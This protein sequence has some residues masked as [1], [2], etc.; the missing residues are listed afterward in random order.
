MAISTY[1]ELKTAVSSWT[2]RSDFTAANLSDFVTLAEANI[3]RD[4]KT[5]QQELRATGT[6]TGET[7]SFPTRTIEPRSLTVEDQ[8]LEYLSPEAYQRK[9]DQDYTEQGYFTLIGRTIY[10]LNG[11]SGDDYVLLYTEHFTGF[12]A[13]T[14]TNWLLT[15]AADVYL[16][17]TCQQAAIFLRDVEGATGYKAL[18]EE[19]VAKLNKQERAAKSM[20]PILVRP[21]VVE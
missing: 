8:P 5:L 21:E 17:A 6:L 9:V 15:N 16:W 11:A 20:G 2:N 19:A 1:A 7:L 18:Y 12:S 4:V 14:D 3:R 13:A 10:V